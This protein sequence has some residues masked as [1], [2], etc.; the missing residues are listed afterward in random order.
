MDGWERMNRIGERK[1]DKRSESRGSRDVQGRLWH[2]FVELHFDRR[3][4]YGCERLSGSLEK[5]LSCLGHG[6]FAEGRCVQYILVFAL[7][8]VYG[9]VGI[10]GCTVESDEHEGNIG[11][12]GEVCS[13]REDVVGDGLLE[14]Q[15]FVIRVGRLGYNDD[16]GRSL[17][18]GSDVGGGQAS[19]G[20]VR[21][22]AETTVELAELAAKRLEWVYCFGIGLGLAAVSR[23]KDGSKKE[24]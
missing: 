8:V 18:D 1:Q 12:A 13:L 2:A 6:L 19:L 3:L 10:R 15:D 16:D 4:S 21:H 5:Q 11:V 14:L 20:N 7:V 17:L 24:D 9:I 22:M 23:C